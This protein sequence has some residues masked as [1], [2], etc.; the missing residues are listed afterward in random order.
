[1]DRFTQV[2]KGG[3][4]SKVIKNI[5]DTIADWALEGKS[6]DKYIVEITRNS[7]EFVQV[8]EIKYTK[9]KK[10]IPKPD[11]P[12]ELV[13]S[14]EAAS[15]RPNPSMRTVHTLSFSNNTSSDEPQ[16]H[17]FKIERKSVSQFSFNLTGGYNFSVNAGIT[18]SP[19]HFP[20]EVKANFGYTSNQSSDE[21][22][23]SDETR[24]K[25]I[26]S[27]IVVPRGKRVNVKLNITE[28]DFIARYEVEYRIRGRV[29]CIVKTKKDD[30]IVVDRDGE[31][32]DIFKGMDG[33]KVFPET[34]DHKGYAKF[35]N[36][37]LFMSKREL[38][39][40]LDI[41]DEDI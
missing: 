17:R 16:K 9:V 31:A 7:L 26:E 11:D 6:P 3:P 29:Y 8:G 20:S 14:G 21:V 13:S 15:V 41:E 12:N 30:T 2:E 25:T 28:E 10:M 23:S 22:S 37:G 35:V 40:E 1:M 39:Q 33:I 27:D 5:D 4:V 19:P 38:K 32:H 24:T 18:L 34:P 36:K